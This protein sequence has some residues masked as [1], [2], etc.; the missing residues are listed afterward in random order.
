MIYLLYGQDTFKGKRK[1][2]EILDFFRAKIGNLGIFRLD[3]DGFKVAELEELL[4][5]RTLFGE[6][7]V[8]VCDRV[9][10]IPA[11]N[12]LVAD[13]IEK[14][15]ES[16]SVFIFFEEE[17]EK[18]ILNLLKDRAQKAQEFKLPA[19]NPEEK[20]NPFPLCDAFASKN[21]KRAWVL[22][23]RAIL[24]GA[25]AEEI[26]WKI[27]WQLKN[28]LLVKKLSRINGVNL[29][30]E[31][32]LKPYPLKKATAAAANFSEEELSD[33]SSKML[34]LYHDARKGRF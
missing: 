34:Q 4:K 8:V 28:L 10:G 14:F 33:Y 6:K 29:A 9:L 30:K 25:P 12:K 27:W 21:K 17:I 19:G 13:N 32:G 2:V 20:Y 31:S 16:Q 23:R 3:G 18:E 1:L 26:F 15:A 24:L 7:Y 22:F 5:S 11:A